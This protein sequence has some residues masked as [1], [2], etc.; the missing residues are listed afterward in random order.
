M[1]RND[2]EYQK[3]S[4]ASDRESINYKTVDDG[5]PN[6]RILHLRAIIYRDPCLNPSAKD[7]LDV[8]EIRTE[9]RPMP[10]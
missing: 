7:Q 2:P 9:I 1:A 6:H 10:I 5:A 3:G 8:T 4:D